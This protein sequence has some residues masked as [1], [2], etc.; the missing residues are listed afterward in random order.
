LVLEK[1]I[2]KQ[3]N[4]C[5]NVKHVSEFSNNLTSQ[6][7]RF[8]LQNIV[9]YLYVQWL[10]PVKFPIRYH[11][12]V[13][14]LLDVMQH[15]LVVSYPCSRT[16]YQSQFQ[17]IQRSLRHFLDCTNASKLGLMGC[18]KMSVTTNL[19]S[20]LWNIPEERI[21]WQQPE[22]INEPRSASNSYC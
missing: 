10:S 18:R 8:N 17:G 7:S 19:H 9:S 15:R 2:H 22:I 20:T 3:F 13:F 1:R 5:V 21:L 14:A 6:H 16:I 4:E 12:K 11:I